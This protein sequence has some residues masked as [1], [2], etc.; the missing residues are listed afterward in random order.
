MTEEYTHTYL[1][2]SE[3]QAPAIIPEEF[4]IKQILNWIG[5]GTSQLE[6]IYNDSITKFKDLMTMAESD[7][8]DI[9]DDYSARPRTGN[10]PQTYSLGCEESRNL[11][12]WFI[13][14]KILQGSIKCQPS[15]T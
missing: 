7:I 11:R 14:C 6:L 3:T 9:A 1:N 8:K 13:G 5:F 10:N 4:Q 15:R 2:V 12:H